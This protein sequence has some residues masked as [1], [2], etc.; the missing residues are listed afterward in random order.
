MIYY[1]ASHEQ[2]NG[3]C[4]G[5]Y[6]GYCSGDY[7]FPINGVAQSWIAFKVQLAIIGKTH[8]FHVA[9]FFF[10]ADGKPH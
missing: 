6:G 3:R 7:P 2:R 5:G 10:M 4:D 1:L 9:A 8:D